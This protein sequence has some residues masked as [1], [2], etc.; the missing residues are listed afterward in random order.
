MI[1][2]IA[3]AIIAGVVLASMYALAGVGL[4]L[5]WGVLK[6]LNFA[7]GSFITL[8]AYFAWVALMFFGE[9]YPVA[10]LFAVG[11]S[12]ML[13]FV[14]NVASIRPLQGRPESE[15]NVFI[16]T[17]ATSIVLENLVIIVFGGRYKP[18]PS[19]VPGS[20]AIG[21]ITINFQQLVIIA[22]APIILVTLMFYLNRMKSGMAVRAVAQDPD[23]ASIVGIDNRKIYSYT[24]AIGCLMAGLAGVLL[25]VIFYLYPGMGG[26]LL[27]R[28]LFVT[29]LGGMG[30]VKGTIYAA[31]II[32]LID[33]FARYFVGLFWASPILFVIFV[34]IILIRPEG[35]YGVKV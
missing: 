7:H 20:I 2:E 12:F 27:V 32:G 8:G 16:A 11:L 33:A 1:A 5:V 17:L 24:I 23:G 18:I 29:V 19:L 25:G 6:V 26:D 14:L 35:L 22:A 3:S 31:Y 28:V 9:N 30:S 34:I 15:N 21:T 4:T 13:G 10:I